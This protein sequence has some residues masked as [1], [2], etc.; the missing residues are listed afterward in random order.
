MEKLDSKSLMIGDWVL[1]DEEYYRVS[2]LCYNDKVITLIQ[3]NKYSTTEAFASE[4]LV[5][6]IPLTE[7]IL[8]KNGFEKSN[9]VSDTQPYDKDEEGNMH[10][11]YNNKFWGW[12]QP[13]GALC[14]P[15][16]ALG[17][18]EFKYVHELQHVLRL[19]KIDKEI[20]L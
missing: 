4:N 11:S 9:N 1:Y 16:N 8:K 7:E 13:N 17:F 19:C 5:T 2:E 18:L 20:E 15:A 3:E 12:F 14:I 6:P 10:Y